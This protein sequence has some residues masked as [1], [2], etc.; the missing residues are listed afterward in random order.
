MKLSTTKELEAMSVEQAEEYY[1]KYNDE[2]AAIR[3]EAWKEA[4][5]S[6]AKPKKV[7]KVE[8][9]TDEE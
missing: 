3:L 8:E 4:N 2:S 6:A 9:K 7:E 1:K 5:P